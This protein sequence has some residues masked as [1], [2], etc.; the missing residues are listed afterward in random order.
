MSFAARATGSNVLVAR[1]IA[2]S[3]AVLNISAIR[4]NETESISA[5]ISKRL[6]PRTTPR[7]STASATMKWMRMLRCVRTT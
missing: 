5:S 2:F 6:A 1:S 3:S 7:G 4:T